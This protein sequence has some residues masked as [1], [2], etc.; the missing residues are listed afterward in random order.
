MKE[1]RVFPKAV[2]EAQLSAATTILALILL[3]LFLAF[4]IVLSFPFPLDN[5]CWLPLL[6]MFFTLIVA[7]W[8]GGRIASHARSVDRETP[9]YEGRA[10]SATYPIMIGLT[11]VLSIGHV[12]I[13]VWRLSEGREPGIV[14]ILGATAFIVVSIATAYTA[15]KSKLTVEPRGLLIGSTAS[16]APPRFIPFAGIK[17]MKLKGKNLLYTGKDRIPGGSLVVEDPE[18]LDFALEMTWRIR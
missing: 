12:A 9:Y 7:H 16:S 15:A 6:G 18:K 3:M 10:Y 1:K 5:L 8:L 17:S 13:I 4:F 14:H 11:L 2:W